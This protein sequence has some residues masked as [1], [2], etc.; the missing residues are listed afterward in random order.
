MMIGLPPLDQIRKAEAD[1]TRRIA[2]A[3]QAEEAAAQDARLQALDLQHQARET[4]RREG[5]AQA[6]AIVA[7]A[8]K[9]ARA[10][11]M[12]AD[13]QAKDLTRAGNLRMNSAVHSAVA[14]VA[15]QEAQAGEP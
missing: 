6:Q 13:S 12:Q 15:G 11:I 5:L 10:L 8:E 3:R 14:I 9:K 4:G 1:V 2:A 7:R